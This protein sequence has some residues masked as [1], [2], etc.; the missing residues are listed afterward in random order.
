M[1]DVSRTL[2]TVHYPSGTFAGCPVKEHER[3]ILNETYNWLSDVFNE[4]FMIIN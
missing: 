2:F 1:P 3:Q 4:W